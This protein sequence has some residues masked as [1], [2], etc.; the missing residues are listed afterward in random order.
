MNS[1]P[2]AS[3][4]RRTAKSLAIVIDVSPSASSARLIVATPKAASRASSAALQRIRARAARIWALCNGFGF[5]LTKLASY[6]I[7]VSSDPNRGFY[8]KTVGSAYGISHFQN[9]ETDEIKLVENPCGP[10]SVRRRLGRP[11]H[12]GQ[13]RRGPDPTLA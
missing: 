7:I 2:A 9:G 5:M 10:P 13:R 1:T 3:S 8:G 11:D 6:D 4:V 12:Y